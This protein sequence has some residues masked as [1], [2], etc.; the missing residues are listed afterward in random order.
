MLISYMRYTKHLSSIGGALYNV[1]E[2][3]VKRFVIFTCMFL[4]FVFDLMC[5][6]TFFVTECGYSL[7]CNTI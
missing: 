7:V 6:E 4:F 2:T 3:H 5:P 1:F